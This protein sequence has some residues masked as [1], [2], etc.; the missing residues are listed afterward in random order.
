NNKPHLIPL[1]HE[2][3]NTNYPG[4]QIGITEYNW[5]AE[6]DPNGATAQA[7]I[8]G[9]FGRE[10]LDLATRWTTP[11][12]GSPAYEAI[13]LYRNYDGKGSAFGDLSVQVSV[14]NPDNVS[15][16]AAMRS[17]D[18]VMTIAVINK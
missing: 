1:M 16:F 12:T 15:A 4:T 6:N 18:S 2:W 9:I 3:V 13:K 5:G 14:P 10:G 7:D 17:S 11:P 8:L